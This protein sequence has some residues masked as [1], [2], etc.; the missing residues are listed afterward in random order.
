MLFQGIITHVFFFLT[1]FFNR[2]VV[3]CG[4]TYVS[5][6]QQSD[7][8]IHTHTHTLCNFSDSLPL[9]VATRY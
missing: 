4:V 7:S 1:I 2:S 3:I 8:V 5:D 9:W 6:A